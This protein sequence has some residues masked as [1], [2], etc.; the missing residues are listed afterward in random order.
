LLADRRGGC[1]SLSRIALVAVL[2]L[3]L[4]A[5]AFALLRDD[6]PVTTEPPGVATQAA[7]AEVVRFTLSSE[8][9]GAELSTSVIVPEG[10]GDRARPLLVFLHGLGGDDRSFTADPALLDALA[11]LGPRAP[12][13]AFPD[14]GT[15]FWYDRP[16][17]DWGDYVVREVIPEVAR[18]AGADPRRVAIGGISMGGFGAY[19]LGMEHP[20]RFC[21]V[22]GHSPA[23]WLSFEESSDFPEAFDDAGAFA[24]NDLIGTAQEDPGPFGETPVWAD[25]GSEDWFLPGFRAFRAALE[26]GDTDLTAR[27]WPGGHDL[28]YWDSHWDSYLRFYAR[29]LAECL[30]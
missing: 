8:E 6:G 1:T 30:R 2:A 23:L 5:G 17:G 4:A 21:G 13:V 27:E 24:E 10:A 26:A 7:G 12:V 15:S 28:A 29:T 9:V 22:G 18:R 14:G 19:Q 3:L 25:T 20:N 11:E 16:S